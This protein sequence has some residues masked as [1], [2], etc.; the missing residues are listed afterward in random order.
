MGAGLLFNGSI[1]D[2]SAESD[3]DCEGPGQEI[4]K[5]KNISRLDVQHSTYMLAKHVAVFAFVLRTCL[6]LN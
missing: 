4:S 2:S 6:R 5:G 1:E 3:M